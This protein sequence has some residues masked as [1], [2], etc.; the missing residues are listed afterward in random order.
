MQVSMQYAAVMWIRIDCIHIQIQVNKITNLISKHL[1]KVRKNFEFSSLNI[2]LRDQLPF[3]YRLEKYNFLRKKKK[4]WLNSAFP[5]IL[6]L[7]IQMNPDP[8]GSESTSLV[9]CKGQIY[10]KQICCRIS[11]RNI[12]FLKQSFEKC[13]FVSCPCFTVNRIALSWSY[14]RFLLVTI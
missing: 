1:L 14:D 11:I 13:I 12:K 7:W 9:C 5:F 4:K 3:R 8:T 2:S 10:E 6:Y